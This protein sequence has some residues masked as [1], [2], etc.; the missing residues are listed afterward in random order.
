MITLECSRFTYDSDMPVKFKDIDFVILLSLN[1][2][3]NIARHWASTPISTHAH[4]FWVGMGAILFSW[5]GMCS[6][7]AQ[8]PHP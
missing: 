3:P 2:H 6:I 4:G 1:W 7:S 5:V 8:S